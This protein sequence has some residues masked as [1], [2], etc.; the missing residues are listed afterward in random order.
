M[1]DRSAMVFAAGV[2]KR[3]G[4][5]TDDRPK[6]LL[7]AGG[8]LLIDHALEVVENAG[9]R[10]CVVN[11]HYLAGMLETHLSG[12]SGV[13]ISHEFPDILETGGGLLAA[14][15]LLGS[16]PTFTLNS[17]MVWL[18][19]NPLLALEANWPAGTAGALLLLSPPERIMAHGGSGD[20]VLDAAG[21]LRR[22]RD[23]EAGLV[24]AGA[25]IIRTDGLSEHGCKSFSLNLEWNRLAASGRLRGLVYDGKWIDAGT[26]KGLRLA[27]ETCSSAS[28]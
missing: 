20:F 27:E 7:P 1:T 10:T 4:S 26:P 24:Y 14:L 17:D 28:T 16:D 18:G 11:T 9:I 2:G 19:P 22:C 25:Q 15:P 12:R 6:P 21:R 8:K 5:L 13:K 23:D 3:M